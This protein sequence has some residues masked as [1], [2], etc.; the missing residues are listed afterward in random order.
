MQYRKLG[1]TGFD[2]SVVA[3]GCWAIAGDQTWGEQDQ[4]DIQPTVDAA[5][6]AGVNLFDTAPGYG[7][8][9]AILGKALGAR[10]KDVIVATKLSQGDVSPSNVI[11]ACEQSLRALGS[12]YIDLYQIHWPDHNVPFDETFGEL[13]KLTA[14]GKVRVLG[15]SN[16]GP[17]DMDDA[18][19]GH[20]FESNQMIYSLLARAIEYEVIPK[21]VQREISILPYSPLAQ[22]LLAG[23]F[24]TAADVPD[25][26]ARTRHFDST[27]RDE[28]RHGERGCEALT[29]A[30]IDQLRSV[31]ERIGAS[32]A[33]VALAWCLHQPAVTSVLAGARHPGQIRDNVRAAALQLDQPTLAELDAITN[34]IKQHLGA[35]PD[36]WQSAENSRIR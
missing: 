34:P 12:D 20:R 28:A 35:N 2:V 36:L 10:R 27:T 21:C 6:D 4:S 25:G 24:A 15:V 33:D 23:K 13:E 26:R 29:F 19:S 16:F 30:A 22:G 1:Q 3:M 14:Q 18:L 11:P 8:S 7:Q 9:E 32:M 17:L 31:C 5:I